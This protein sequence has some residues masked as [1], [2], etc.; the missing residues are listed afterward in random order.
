MSMVVS[1]T[2]VDRS[3]AY[4]AGDRRRALSEGRELSDRVSGTAL[5]ADVSGFT[6]LTEALA[7]ELGPQRG[8]EELTAHLNRVFHAVIDDVERYGGEVIYFG[9]D[10]ITCW[11][12]GDEGRRGAACGLAIQRTMSSVGTIR[13]P[14]G[15]E[16]VLSIKVA[17]AVGNARR[18]VVGDPGIQLIDVL[19][20]RL[21]DELADAEHLAEK[22]DV[23]LARSALAALGDQVIVHEY[24]DDGQRN[25]AVGVLAGLRID[26]DEAEPAPALPPLSEALVRPWILPAVYERLVTGRGEF[27]AELRSAYP[28]FVRFGGID[29]DQDPDAVGKLDHFTQRVQ[30]ILSES[31][32][33]L[34][35]VILGDKGAY[36]CAVFGTPHAHEDDASR[37]ATAAIE[38]LALDRE[39]A[40]TDLQVGISHGRVR[41]GAYGHPM[42]RTFT[43]LGD[44]VNLSARL[45]S[46]A[47]AGQAYI[48]EDVH[49]ALSERVECRLVGD[50]TVKGKAD[51][52]RVMSIVGLRRGV[53]KREIRYSLPMVGRD[54]EMAV[55]GRAVDAVVGGSG[56]VV[57]VAAEAGRGKSRLIAEVVRNLTATGISV[58]WGEAQNFGRTTSYLVW[59]DV[60]RTLLEVDDDA[61]EAAQ[62]RDLTRRLRATSVD[63]ARRGPLLGSVLGIGIEDNDLTRTFDAKLR[64]T[65]LESLLVD[66]LRARAG[67]GALAIVLEDCHWIDG[68]S[69]DLLE[70]LVLASASLPVLFVLAY[71]PADAPGGALGLERTTYFQELHLGE[72]AGADAQLVLRAKLEQLFGESVQPADE[73]VAL[74]L[75]RAQGNPFY[76]EELINYV[77]GHGIDPADP[78]ALLQLEIP[79]T[80]FRLVQSRIDMLDEAPRTALK[81]ASVVGRTFESP[82]VQGVYPDLGS[83]EQVEVRFE[84]ARRADILRIDRVE[85]RSWLFR[86]VVARDVAYDSLPFAMRAHLHDRVGGFLESGGQ[87]AIERNLDLLAYHYWLGED[88]AKK[89]EYVVRAGIAAQSRYANDAAADYFQRALPLLPD[90][91]RAGVLRRLGKVLE[92]R[93]GWA[94]AEATYV[95]A[96]ELSMRLGDAVEQAWSHADLAETLRKQ[97]R[98]EDARHQLVLASEIFSHNDDDAGLGLVLH[99]EGTLASQQGQYDAAR[100][101][102]EKSLEIRERLGDRPSIGSLLSNLALVAECEGDLEQARTINERA[103]A[104][105]EEVGDRW[106]ICVSQNNL[107]MIALLQKDFTVARIRFEASMRLAS[108]IGDR[109][110]V[111]V[112]HHNLGNTNLGLGELAKAG[113]GLLQA[114]QAYED[115]ND[116][117][118]VALLVEDMVL[119]AL[120]KDE[121]VHAVELIGA[122][123]ALRTRLEAPR[124]PAVTVALEGAVGLV[125]PRLGD[126]EFAAHHRGLNLDATALGALLRVVGR[127]TE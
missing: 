5:F 99:L 120:A 62:G 109:W 88:D 111:A 2:Y 60:W 10:A 66:L 115:Y 100:A 126:R 6:P 19:A 78:A 22:G 71:R 106:A 63:L 36:L 104:I 110:V 98:F 24:R 83:V 64:K 77:H 51:A 39:T 58:A 84:A 43:C 44:A 73:L 69:R 33:N 121:I 123:D 54:V 4:L 61:S 127:S 124:P 107:G 96:I 76:L 116:L 49:R 8:A 70:E 74:V 91:E 81:V 34:L 86:H 57:G 94:H 3:E 79:D 125:R 18:F 13:T 48:S 75:E 38:L 53:T 103:L 32:G 67:K 101:A 46:Q 17:V 30:Q 72:L 85:D 87:Q 9:G 105:R 102:Y 1:D 55:F 37:A 47:P 15:I 108:E 26:V 40:V 16:V 31:G 118:S 25:G 11:L 35:H 12:D 7:N 23:V 112:G 42:R 21:I 59:R 52:V 92:L 95:E 27:L 113:D 119:L 65:S 122:A 90:A 93:G 117:W 29:Y 14:A 97:G 41:S 28:V 20:G 56:R 50:L 68:L 45:M 80:L 89:R 82:F 114:L